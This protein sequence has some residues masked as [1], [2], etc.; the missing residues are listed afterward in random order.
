[1]INR[2]GSVNKFIV[3]HIVPQRFQQIKKK[4]PG[5]CTLLDVAMKLPFL[6]QVTSGSGYPVT[7]HVMEIS[8][9]TLYSRPLDKITFAVRGTDENKFKLN[10]FQF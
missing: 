5:I 9:P 2:C 6:Y 10:N 3:L 7:S 1:M 8:L 4:L